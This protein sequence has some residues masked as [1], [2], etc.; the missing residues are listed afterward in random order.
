MSAS[1]QPVESDPE[2]YEQLASAHRRFLAQW[3]PRFGPH[4]VESLARQNAQGQFLERLWRPSGTGRV[5]LV[6]IRSHP[7][8]GSR[9]HGIW[10]RPPGAESL[11]RLLADVEHEMATPIEAVTDIL[12]EMDADAQARFFRPK[13]FWHRAKVL[14]ARPPEPLGGD[15]SSPPQVRPIE[16]SDLRPL[17]GVYVRAYSNRPGEFWT[18]SSPTPWPDAE[19]D[20]MG[21]LTPGGDW[22]DDFLPDRSFV[23][24]SEGR[25]LG[26]ALVSREDGGVA[27]VEDL[28]VEPSVHRQGIGR[29]LL[30]NVIRAAL[31]NGPTSV[32]LA[33]IR[34]GAPYRLYQRLGFAEVP[35]PAGTLDGH[36]IR[37]KDP[38]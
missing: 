28:I 17:I 34:S 32:E 15:G 31:Q 35:A 2:L 36:W 8:A 23:W 25:V 26:G 24:E 38:W 29:S 5:G 30:E 14:M 21:H 27:Y 33:A 3:H 6:R 13:G 9:L 22:T 1:L 12:P 18:W 7:A 20:V 4:Q 16:K 19:S 37:G 10:I 11:E